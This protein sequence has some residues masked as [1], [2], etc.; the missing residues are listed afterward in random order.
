MYFNWLFYIF[1]S[2]LKC[3]LFQF[4]SR[5]THMHIPILTGF[6]NRRISRR[7][8]GVTCLLI[9]LLFANCL[10]YVL[11]VYRKCLLFLFFSR[12]IR[13]HIPIPTGF[14][15]GRISRWKNDYNLPEMYFLKL[16]FQLEGHWTQI[17]S[18][19]FLLFNVNR[20]FFSS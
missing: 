19:I 18:F 14:Q 5:G 16:N 7:K 3:F 15:N 4:L 17:P 9:G 11:T 8:N 12:G 13:M 6:Q 20:F 10:F 1:S 2:C